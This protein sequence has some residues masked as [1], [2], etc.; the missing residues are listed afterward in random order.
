LQKKRKGVPLIDPTPM[1][2]MFEQKMENEKKRFE[3]EVEKHKTMI[4]R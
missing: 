2:K 4:E 3:K 1:R